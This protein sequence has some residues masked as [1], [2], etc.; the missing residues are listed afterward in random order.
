M[1]TKNI[2]RNGFEYS[3]AP[4]PHTRILKI[5]L[6]GQIET[7]VF[8]SVVCKLISRILENVVRV[9]LFPILTTRFSRTVDSD[10]A[11]YLKL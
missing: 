6:R 3:A 4:R 11:C 1:Q 5:K 9:A 2:I 7:R 8:E 10:H